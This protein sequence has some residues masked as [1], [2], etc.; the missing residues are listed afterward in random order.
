MKEF[1]GGKPYDGSSAA[2]GGGL[3]GSTDTGYFYFFCPKC[4][5]KHIMRILEYGVREETQE[6]PYNSEFKK[7]AKNG[8]ILAFKL[9]CENCKHNDFV[10]IT[11]T[12]LQSGT[13]AQALGK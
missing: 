13:H 5:D 6:N 10:K 12:G 1:N 3:T 2:Q 7:K 8:F 11:N 9:Y 4:P